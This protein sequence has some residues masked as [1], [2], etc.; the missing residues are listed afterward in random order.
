MPDM[1]P[2]QCLKLREADAWLEVALRSTV[3]PTA[4]SY[5][6]VA[7]EYTFEAGSAPHGL[8]LEGFM[9]DR[10]TDWIQR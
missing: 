1:L 8:A 9:V 2:G 10:P 3:R 4:F 5:E 7:P 6:H